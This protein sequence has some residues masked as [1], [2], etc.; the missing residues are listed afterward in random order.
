MAAVQLINN[1]SRSQAI[2]K[3][4]LSK[5]ISIQNMRDLLHEGYNVMRE[6]F[7][8]ML[9]TALR[10]RVSPGVSFVVVIIL[11]ILEG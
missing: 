11:A 2:E 3:L 6:C 10:L 1:L 5:V 7:G 9:S 4:Y 8:V